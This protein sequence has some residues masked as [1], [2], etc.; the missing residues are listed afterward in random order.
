M[1]I[2]AVMA[3]FDPAAPESRQAAVPKQAGLTFNVARR[4]ASLATRY[5]RATIRGL[6]HI[7]RQGPALIVAN[8]GIFG[9]DTPVFFSLIYEATGRMPIGLAERL[10]VRLKPMRAVLQ[11]IGGVEGTRE[12][13]LSLLRQGQLVVCYPGGAR[14][15]FKGRGE[16][17]RLAW[18]KALGFA[19][20][21]CLTGAPVI[22]VAAIGVDDTFR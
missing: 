5:H 6:E 19:R 4:V 16:R 12:N 1:A 7:P 13:A 10:L 8:H 21:A 20:V 22:P 18:K 17:H 2:L 14:E 9:F 15:V 11:E 3:T